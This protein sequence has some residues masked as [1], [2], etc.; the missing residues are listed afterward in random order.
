MPTA[1]GG[2]KI[3]I[4]ASISQAISTGNVEIA[5]KMMELY[6]RMHAK[7]A[8]E[9]FDKAMAKFQSECPT[10]K[11][12]KAVFEKDGRTVRYR[13]APLD[14]IVDQTRKP[15]ADNGLSYTMKTKQGEGMLT[16]VI[17]VKHISGHSEDSEF[18]VPIGSEQFMSEVQ[19]FGARATFAKRYAFCNA[20]GILTGDDDTDAKGAKDKKKA[21]EKPETTYLIQLKDRLHK[22]GAK[23][24]KAALKILETRT[25]TKWKNFEVN[26][27]QAQY[28]LGLL[29]NSQRQGK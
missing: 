7:W 21:E 22:M 12:T 13:F 20:F 9:Q 28:A 26:E 1:P 2:I 17:T 29:L 6:E 18:S 11:K 23:N 16:I 27:G 10:V 8:K 19:K 5:E 15:I 3:D 14:S 25:G 4:Q 24:E